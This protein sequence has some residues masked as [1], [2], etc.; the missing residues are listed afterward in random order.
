MELQ[1]HSCLTFVNKSSLTNTMYT[2]AVN[3]WGCTEILFPPWQ[4]GNAIIAAS[5]YDVNCHFD[6]SD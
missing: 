4:C 6:Y 3:A 1:Y 2:M 5:S